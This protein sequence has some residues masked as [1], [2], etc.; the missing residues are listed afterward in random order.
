MKLIKG[1]KKTFKQ[2]REYFVDPQR[3]ESAKDLKELSGVAIEVMAQ[4]FA[5]GGEMSRMSPEIVTWLAKSRDIGG[6]QNILGQVLEREIGTR[7]FDNKSMAQIHPQGNKIGILSM[8]V[9]A[10]MNTNTIVKEVSR[11]EHRMEYEA[12]VW[13]SEMFGYDPE[14]AS[15]NITTGGTLANQVALW[16][17]RDAKV[18]E[19]GGDRD[20]RNPLG[21]LTVLTN[22]YSHYSVDKV[23]H[24][25]GMRLEK[26]PADGYK[27]DVGA[28]K[29]KLIEMDPKKRLKIAAIVAVAGETETAQVDDLEAIADLCQEFNI[30]LHVD[31]A[32]GGPFILSRKGYLFKG[33]DRA[34]SITVDP[35]KMMWTPY[36]AG[37]V[38]FKDKTKH[39]LI[40]NEARYL[41]VSTNMGLTGRQSERN[42]GLSARGE[43]SMGSG[44]VIATWATIKL[45]GK[46]G[47]ASLLDHTLDM[48]EH[49]YTRVGESEVLCAWQELELNEFLVG[50][51]LQNRELEGLSKDRY[52]E[53]M[54]L[55]KV[56]SDQ[57]LGT[58]ISLNEDIDGGRH[59]WRFIVV[60]PYTTKADINELF[61]N[62][63]K[64]VVRLAKGDP[65]F[66]AE[67]KTIIEREKDWI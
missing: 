63:E 52:N 34:D 25:L 29:R 32:Y 35:H 20:E 18:L 1:Q 4:I 60:H 65:V 23:C 54:L 58:Y 3:A 6:P 14:T 2:L 30:H 17:A 36:S 46:E 24:Q 21:R 45:F 43:G 51:N 11:G 12:I 22:S 19:L 7:R 61:G 31:A 37:A 57:V 64:T 33:I 56:Y 44:G 27:T 48:A 13:L 41:Q 62:L 49:A 40:Q 53:V 50:L 15:G 42:F 10:Y 47:L 5:S 55:A 26:L 39:A 28:L 8:L 38:L 9:A 66:E 59:A 67:I 16:V